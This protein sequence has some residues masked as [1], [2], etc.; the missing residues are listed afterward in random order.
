[1]SFILC[2][3]L[4]LHA[5]NEEGKININVKDASVKEVLEVLKKY[6]YRLVYSTVID[7][8]KKKITDMKKATSAGIG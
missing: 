6:N 2:L 4:P 1:M 7:A 5:Q 3:S 8:C